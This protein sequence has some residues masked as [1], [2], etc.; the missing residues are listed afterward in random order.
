MAADIDFSAL[1]QD[2][3][4]CDQIA[5][6]NRAITGISGFAVTGC[7][8]DRNQAAWQAGTPQEIDYR[9]SHT[10]GVHDQGGRG[11]QQLGAGHQAADAL[12]D[13]WAIQAE[14]QTL[15]V[16]ERTALLDDA[17]IGY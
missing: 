17:L 1:H 10:R 6:R 13:G 4:T 8:G 7:N 16:A 11:T 15:Q 14:G 2:Q 3:Q 12:D 5:C 9:P